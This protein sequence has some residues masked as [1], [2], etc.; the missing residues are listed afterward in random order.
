MGLGMA[1]I[2]GEVVPLEQA[3]LAITDDGAARGDGAFE[4][5]G[6]WSGRAFRLADH[7]QRLNRSLSAILLPAV[8][9]EDVEADARRLLAG[10]EVDAMLR[11]YV[12]AGGTRL[13]YLAPQP[14]RPSPT[15]LVP[16]QAPWIR[17][18]GTYG[19]A[20]AKTMSYAPNMTATRAAVAAGGEDALLTSLEGWVLEGP[21]FAV[22]WAVDGR[23]HTAP[24]D[25]G[26]VD[27]ISRRAVLELARAEGIETVVES[28]P[29]DHLMAADEVMACSAV[30]PLV[31]VRQVGDRTFD[32]ATPVRDVLA[33]GLAAARRGG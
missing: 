31:A 9:V 33:E 12:T 20:G 24:V 30:R 19:P 28:R 1:V 4:S 32:A 25:L 5:A 29:L 26:I 3:V 23:L 14:E 2:N 27:S 7:L 10:V 17:P 16:L 15:H 18:L 6:V 13:V 21:T 11:I 8:A 22:L